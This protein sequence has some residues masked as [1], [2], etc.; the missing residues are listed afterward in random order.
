MIFF[1]SI[2]GV[3]LVVSFITFIVAF[4]A[5]VEGDK[6]SSLFFVISIVVGLLAYAFLS[7]IPRDNYIPNSAK[8]VRYKEKLYDLDEGNYY[9]LK[10]TDLIII[11]DSLEVQ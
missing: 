1:G 11:S 2:I 5:M 4:W 3:L 10:G 8:V 6:K 7:N 9:K